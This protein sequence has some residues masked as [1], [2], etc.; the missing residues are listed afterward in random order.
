MAIRRWNNAREYPRKEEEEKTFSETSQEP[1]AQVNFNL[2]I[3]IDTAGKAA[4]K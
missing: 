1:L 4:L 3:I 2:K